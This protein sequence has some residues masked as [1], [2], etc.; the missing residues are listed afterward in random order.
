MGQNRTERNWGAPSFRW[1]LRLTPAYLS[2]HLLFSLLQHYYQ[3]CP[4]VKSICMLPEPLSHPERYMSVH[5]ERL[6][7]LAV[8]LCE[9]SCQ[10][11][12]PLPSRTLF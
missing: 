7:G 8:A 12:P 3:K 6:A 1:T 2:Y 4:S 9:E 10:A 5:P 11:G